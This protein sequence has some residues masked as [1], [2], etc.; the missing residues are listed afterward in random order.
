MNS[1][2]TGASAP[3]SNAPALFLQN[4][5][6]GAWG[7]QV[8]FSTHELG[9]FEALREEALPAEALAARCG[10]DL[11]GLE[12]LL[13]AAQAL[14]LL[15]CE[16]GRY[17][18]ATPTQEHMIRGLPGYIGDVITH[19]GRD[20]LPL[21]NHL[22]DAVREGTSRWRQVTGSSQAHFQSLYS[23][24]NKLQ[25]FMGTMDLYA[26]MSAAEIADAFDFSRIH[27]LL[28]VGGATGALGRVLAERFPHV[29]VTVLELDEMCSAVEA[30]YAKRGGSRRPKMLAGDM[31]SGPFDSGHDAIHFGWVLHNWPPDVQVGLLRRAHAALRPGG[32]VLATECLLGGPDPLL[33]ALLSLDMFVSTDGGAESTA[34]QYAERFRQAGLTMRITE[35]PG[36]RTLL[37]A[38]KERETP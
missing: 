32:F 13:T 22:T 37:W 16:Q 18:N 19:L 5:A 29:E 23:D 31:L 24:P 20:V 12:I 11:R 35:L 6:L 30:W 28:D 3:S 14:G 33:P 26:A 21:W 36:M 34:A 27:S 4:L 17:A 1:E 2:R 15:V 9:V 10:T 8:L 38:E 25:A 7:A